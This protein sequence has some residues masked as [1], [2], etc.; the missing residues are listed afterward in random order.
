MLKYD[1]NSFLILPMINYEKIRADITSK[2]S[3]WK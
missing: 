3:P 1:Y 2:Y